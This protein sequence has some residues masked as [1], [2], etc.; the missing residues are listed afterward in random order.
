[1]NE[2]LTGLEQ[3]DAAFQSAR[4]E[5]WS[6]GRKRRGRLGERA[7]PHSAW[8]VETT[9]SASRLSHAPSLSLL[10]PDSHGVTCTYIL[11]ALGG[12]V[13][14]DITANATKRSKVGFPRSHLLELPFPCLPGIGSVPQCRTAAP[15]KTMNEFVLL[16]AISRPHT[17]HLSHYAEL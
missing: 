4:G 7:I 5:A 14:C 3:H 6:R 8:L 9:T 15:Q 2:G 13:R 16:S 12:E 17:N 11:D 1:M 10:E